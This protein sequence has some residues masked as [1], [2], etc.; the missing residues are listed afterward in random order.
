[1]R[2]GD[3]RVYI[4]IDLDNPIEQSFQCIKPFSFNQYVLAYPIHHTYDFIF[5]H[6][7]L[8]E[9]DDC[10]SILILIGF[11]TNPQNHFIA[12]IRQGLTEKIFC[13]NDQNVQYCSYKHI[14]HSGLALYYIHKMNKQR[15]SYLDLYNPLNLQNHVLSFQ[16][17]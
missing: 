10:I 11:K 9:E 4:A 13:I 7:F 1:M 14:K 6:Q 15:D 2:G 16:L 8:V 12:Y 17:A 3:I 5:P